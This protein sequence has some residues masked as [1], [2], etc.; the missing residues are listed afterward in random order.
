MPSTNPIFLNNNTPLL[1]ASYRNANYRVIQGLADNNK[2]VIFFS[3]NALYYPNTEDCFRKT[4]LYKDR[5]EW[6]AVSSVILEYVSRVILVRDIKK[7]WYVDGISDI[8]DTVNKTVDLLRELCKGYSVYTYG[9]S[10]GGYM[11]VYAGIKLNAKAVFNWGGQID[12]RGKE[13]YT[14]ENDIIKEALRDPERSSQLDLK[15]VLK[16]NEVPVYSFYAADNALDQDE[17][18]ELQDAKNMRIIRFDSDK[19][20]QGFE[21]DVYVNLIQLSIESLDD[22]F[23]EYEAKKA[24]VK[25][26]GDKINNSVDP[27]SRYTEVKE[28]ESVLQK[29][30]HKLGNIKRKMIKR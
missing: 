21:R 13:I 5:Y 22:L 20:G 2:C 30:R 8:Y 4:V 26:T 24:P 23:K 1:S 9:N 19:H 25:E 7:S 17:L 11:A 3:G 15:A 16:D 29:V 18:K 10:A 14:Q 28:K 12:I 27:S 6:A